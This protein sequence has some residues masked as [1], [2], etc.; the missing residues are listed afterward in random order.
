MV[1]WL[2]GPF[3]NV[4]ELRMSPFSSFR[5]FVSF[6]EIWETKARLF[7]FLKRRKRKAMGGKIRDSWMTPSAERDTKGGLLLLIR[8]WQRRTRSQKNERRRRRNATQKPGRGLQK[9]F[10]CVRGA[11]PLR[12]AD[13]GRSAICGVIC[14]HRR[15]STPSPRCKKKR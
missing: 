5:L 13:H 1:G 8:R 12:K 4:N 14:N 9:A 6:T 7:F 10:C 11:L 2:V 15:R 3:P